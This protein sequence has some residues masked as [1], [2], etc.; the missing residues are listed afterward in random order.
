MTAIN[1]A[2][3]F[4]SRA[5]H[6]GVSVDTQKLSESSEVAFAMMGEKGD[7][8]DQDIFNTARWRFMNAKLY[9]IT[10]KAFS[11]EEI[12]ICYHGRRWIGATVSH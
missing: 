12:D 5:L 6:L 3:F 1:M 10:S 8:R 7:N 9:Y 11:R 4:D 2:L